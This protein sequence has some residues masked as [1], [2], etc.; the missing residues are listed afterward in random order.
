MVVVDEIVGL[1]A[2]WPWRLS[3]FSIVILLPFIGYLV[4]EIVP[5]WCPSLI[6]E[7]ETDNRQALSGTVLGVAMAKNGL[8]W[9]KASVYPLRTFSC[10]ELKSLDI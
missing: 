5:V 9:L 4:F 6:C 7:S 8:S 2:P 10:S 1:P 3:L